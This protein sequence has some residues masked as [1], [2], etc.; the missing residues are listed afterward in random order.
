MYY[1][2]LCGKMNELLALR[3]LANLSKENYFCPVIEPVKE[4]LT[5]LVKT[6]E[7]LNEKNIEPLIIINPERGDFKN[8][9]SII[10]ENLSDHNKDLSYLPCYKLYEINQ[11]IPKVVKQLGKYA[12]F[13]TGGI[14][15][16]LITQ[17]HN[18]ELV[19]INHDTA[20][21]ILKK[22]KNVVLCGDFFR[23]QQRNADYPEES[24]FSS[25]HTYYSD[26]PTV[27]GFGDYTIVGEE[28]SESGGP[29]YVVAIHAPYIDKKRFN[30]MFIRHYRSYDDNTPT[31]PGNKFLDALS[32]FIQELDEKTIPFVD[33]TGV[34]EFRDL[35][36]SH[37]F[38]GLGQVKK[39]SIKHHIETI[40]D[41][42]EKDKTGF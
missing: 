35:H 29:A 34:Q 16:E 17:S 6:I 5:S 3:D 21:H 13:F 22:L 19:F 26:F 18:A 30:E 37:H 14:T 27:V 15:E 41:F 20:P 9:Y 28:F 7:E 2:I 8:Q 25:L 39:I 36:Q 4:N 11:E 10:T 40:I 33:T 42:L 38:P 1:P 32:Q 23:R 24:A 31:N 12:L